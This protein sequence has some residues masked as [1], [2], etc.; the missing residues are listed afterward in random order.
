MKVKA[1]LFALGYAASAIAQAQETPAFWKFAPTPVM[2]WN[3][4]D[5]F[6]TTVTESQ[7]KANA[8]VM[9]NQLKRYGWQYIVVDI[10]WYEPH[11]ASFEYR[12]DAKLSMDQWGRLLPAVNRFPSAA[13]GVGFKALADYVHSQGLKF[14]L[15][16]MRGI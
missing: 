14:G 9:A 4:W 13:N 8:D 11:A 6:A 12:K 2:G 3:S 5:C 7:T 1:I 16:I 15:H 10:Q